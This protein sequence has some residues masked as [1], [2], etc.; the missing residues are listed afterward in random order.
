LRNA[1]HPERIA[2]HPDRIALHPDRIAL[3]PVRNALN[4]V[5]NAPKPCLQYSPPRSPFWN[6]ARK[7][8]GASTTFQRPPAK[9]IFPNPPGNTRRTTSAPCHLSQKSIILKEYPCDSLGSCQ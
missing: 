9:P 7:N 2:P 4:R 1:L 6:L 8:P 5:R 3:N